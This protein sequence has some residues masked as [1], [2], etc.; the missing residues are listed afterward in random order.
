VAGPKLVAR[1][2]E[3]EHRLDQVVAGRVLGRLMI[4]L[5]PVLGRGILHPV[6]EQPRYVLRVGCV[7]V[8]V[9][10]EDEAEL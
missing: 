3:T 10:K 8:D 5:S 1:G 4:S 7:V 2:V 6:L 9:V